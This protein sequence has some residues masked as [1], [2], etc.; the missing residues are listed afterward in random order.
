M[1]FVAIEG[2]LNCLSSLFFCVCVCVPRPVVSSLVATVG[3]VDGLPTTKE[4][5][6][7]F[8]GSLWAA[9]LYFSLHVCPRLFCLVCSFSS[10]VSEFNVPV[11]TSIM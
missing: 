6:K 8:L 10:F 3:T 4:K 7:Q 2:S 9:F 1:F 11:I 5:P